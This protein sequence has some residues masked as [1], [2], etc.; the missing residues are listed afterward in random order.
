M[1]ILIAGTTYHPALN[2]QAM[3][4]KN[5]AEGLAQ[6]GHE[7]VAIFPSIEGRAYN[8]TRNGVRLEGISSVRLSLL[9]PDAFVAVYSHKRL[10][11]IFDATRP[12][13]V[14][15]QDHYPLSRSIAREALRRGIKLVAT[16]SEE[17]R[18][19]KECRS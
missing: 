4:T 8:R 9:H 5:L 11:C 14:H 16:R 19:G 7:V 18:V 6:R 10:R 17:R 15:I 2:G 12:E 13:V 3:F 1:H